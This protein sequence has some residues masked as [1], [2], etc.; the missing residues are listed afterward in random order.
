[1][2]GLT[3]EQDIDWR[4]HGALIHRTESRYVCILVL[5]TFCV[6]KH[7]FLSKVRTFFGRLKVK[8]FKVNVRKGFWLEGCL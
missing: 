1:M 6:P 5:V 3:A 8:G 4:P 2:N 7:S